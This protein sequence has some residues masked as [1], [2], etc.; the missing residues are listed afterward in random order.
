MQG[1][2]NFYAGLSEN[3]S[4]GGVF[5]ATSHALPIGTPVVLQFTLPTSDA[6]LTVTGTVKW[7]RGPDATADRGTLF[8]TGYEVPG[9]MPGLGVQFHGVDADAQY[10]IRAFMEKRSPVFFDA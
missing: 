4:E 1:E 3:L 2:N 6:P 7:V 10:A 8:G 5:I 9:V